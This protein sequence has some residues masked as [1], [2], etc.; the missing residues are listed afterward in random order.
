MAL[1]IEQRFFVSQRRKSN[2][3][4]VAGWWERAARFDVAAAV[5]FTLGV[6]HAQSGGNV[7]R[8]GIA[9]QEEMVSVPSGRASSETMQG[10]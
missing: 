6:N 5:A 7:A 4:V 1:K 10:L 2:G 8:E 3:D 9:L